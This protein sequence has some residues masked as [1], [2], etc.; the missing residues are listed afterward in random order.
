MSTTTSD[1]KYLDSFLQDHPMVTERRYSE[2]ELSPLAE[3]VPEQVLA[4]LT[5]VGKASW[6]GFFFTQL[7]G[8]SPQLL[9]AWGIDPSK[10]HLFMTSALGLLVFATK[11]CVYALDP[12]TGRIVEADPYLAFAMLFLDAMTDYPEFESRGLEADPLEPGQQWGIFPPIKL[13]GTFGNAYGSKATVTFR[14]VARDEHAPY[15]ASL[16][17][18]KPKGLPKELKLPKARAPKAPVER[19]APVVTEEVETFAFSDAGLHYAV[20]SALFA[21]GELSPDDLQGALRKHSDVSEDDDEYEHIARAVKALRKLRLREDQLAKVTTL[22]RDLSFEGTFERLIGVETGGEDDY[23]AVTSL[24]ELGRLP[25][26]TRLDLE[27][28][29]FDST[30]APDLA[31]LALHPALRELV[32]GRKLPKKLDAL[33]KA[34]H[35]ERLIVR[36]GSAI[37]SKVAS[38]LAKRNVVVERA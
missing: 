12:N 25:A 29:T 3:Q 24:R 9:E 31:P 2:A 33:T 17:G 7:P 10:A 34:P 20:V 1:T 35:L 21:A 37:D 30:K 4:L 36:E 26:L 14:K 32:L 27:S 22:G 38:A 23:M 8:E 18:N 19:T 11:E 5:R 16:F 13:G 6:K 28:V 15:L